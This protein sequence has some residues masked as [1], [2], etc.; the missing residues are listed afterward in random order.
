MTTD[1]GQRR[2]FTPI[3]IFKPCAIVMSGAVA[4]IMIGAVYLGLYSDPSHP[5]EDE[6]NQ[7]LDRSAL[8]C[9]VERIND[10]ARP[11]KGGPQKEPKNCVVFRSV[12]AQQR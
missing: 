7:A 5:T 1:E 11:T 12:P 8:L 3:A 9:I 6:R 2:R 10:A 4:A